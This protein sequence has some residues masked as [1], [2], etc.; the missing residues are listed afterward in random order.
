MRYDC[1][2]FGKRELEDGLMHHIPKPGDV[3]ENAS[4]F[5]ARFGSGGGGP[6]SRQRGKGCLWLALIVAV[7]ILVVWLF[8]IN[9]TPTSQ[10]G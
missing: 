5:R 6:G 3:P 8:F 1:L 2:Q 7:L 10:V 4:D 9:T